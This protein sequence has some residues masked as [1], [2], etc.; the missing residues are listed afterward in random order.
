MMTSQFIVRQ[1]QS[2]SELAQCAE[3]DHAYTTN[4]VWQMDARDDEGEILVRFRTARLPRGM[5][6]AYPRDDATLRTTWQQRDCFLVA[7]TDSLILGYVNMRVEASRSGWIQDLIVDAPVRRKRIGSALLEQAARWARLRKLHYL[8]LELQTK[9][10]P[11]ISFA[12][13]HGFVFCGYNDHF[14]PNQD[15]ALFFSKSL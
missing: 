8:T 9:N 15:V 10:Y 14:Y 2:D 12:Q 1:L 7:A 4:C 13:T 6:V 11:G 3:L 5:L